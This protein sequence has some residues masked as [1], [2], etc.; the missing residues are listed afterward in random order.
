MT[1]VIDSRIFCYHNHG[2]RRAVVSDNYEGRLSSLTG[3][4]FAKKKNTIFKIIPQQREKE[5]Y[6]TH[7]KHGH[8]G[9]HPRSRKKYDSVNLE[10]RTRN[11]KRH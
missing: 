3:S 7:E 10:Q 9:H 2:L 11:H 1:R 5:R 8:K 6:E 4:Q